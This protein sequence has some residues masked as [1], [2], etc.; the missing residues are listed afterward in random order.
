MKSHRHGVLT[1]KP[2]MSVVGSVVDDAFVKSL[3]EYSDKT[4]ITAKDRSDVAWKKYGDSHGDA[5]TAVQKFKT[6]YG[7]GVSTMCTVYNARYIYLLKYLSGNSG[8]PMLF[9]KEHNYH[10]HI[11]KYGYPATIQNGQWGFFLHVHPSGA[12]VGSEAAVVYT[13]Q[14]PNTDVL[15][16]W[17]NPYSGDNRAY[18][19]VREKEHWPGTGTWEYMEGR[20][21][22]AS[23][24]DTYSNFLLVGDIGQDSSPI[25]K[26]S[27]KM[28]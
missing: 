14:G 7:D 24:S 23:Y 9:S 3:P 19:E 2:A 25:C 20:F 22:S 13:I 8:Y 28:T 27:V 4:T 16:M 10:G 6:E 26:W 1:I 5:L 15:A 17:E 21:S 18:G 12:A 11:D